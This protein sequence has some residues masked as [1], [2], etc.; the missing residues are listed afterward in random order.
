MDRLLNESIDTRD[1]LPI[2]QHALMRTWNVWAENDGRGA[3]DLDHYERS[4]TL[5]NALC[6]HADEALIDLAEDDRLI[7]ERM[8]QALTETDA[9]NRRIRR[10]AH[11]HQIAAI[12]GQN[13]LPDKVMSLIKRFN[14]ENRNFLVLSTRISSDDPLLDISH[15]SLIRQ[16]KTLADW[17]DQEAESARIYRRLAQ[18]AE[19]HTDGKAGLYKETDLQV[20]LDWQRQQQPNAEWAARYHSNFNLVM[21]FL[22]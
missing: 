7:A 9:S 5:K 3:I 21:G 20:A 14:A 12:C 1:D 15:E 6:L 10:P 17:V 4:G 19:L 11:L 18:S 2:L 8:F 16:W 22:E 13:V